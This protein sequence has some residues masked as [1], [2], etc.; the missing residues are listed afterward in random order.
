MA[1]R[2]GREEDVEI[3]TATML[4]STEGCRDFTSRGVAFRD[5]SMTLYKEA[6]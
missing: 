5:R 3:L 2:H 6:V 1:R 4:Q